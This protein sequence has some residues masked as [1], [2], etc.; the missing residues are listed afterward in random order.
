MADTKFEAVIEGMNPYPLGDHRTGKRVFV[1]YVDFRKPRKGEY[2]LS[3]AIA[4]VW[5]A[6]SDIQNSRFHIVKPTHYAMR[7]QTWAK[8]E[9]FK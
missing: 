8:G 4:E 6:P 7:V 9:E 2:Y 5:Q 1:K 3:G